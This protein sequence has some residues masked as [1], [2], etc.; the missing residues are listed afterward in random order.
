LSLLLLGKDSNIIPGVEFSEN[1]A[2]TKD[3]ILYLVEVL[4]AWQKAGLYLLLIIHLATIVYFWQW[5][6][7]PAHIN[8]GWTYAVNTTLIGWIMFLPW[9]FFFFVLRMKKPNPRLP[10]PAYL[11]AAMVVTKAP[12]EPLDMV[13]K[14][15]N[16]MI[17]QTYPHDTWL[18]DED[19]TEEIKFWCK[20]HGVRI[21]TRKGVPEYNRDQWPRRKKSKEGNL[22]F[23]YDHYGYANYDVVCQLDADHIPGEKY[24]EEMIRPF[25]DPAV[26]YVSAPSICD[27]NA[28]KSWTARSRLYAEAFLHGAQQ[29]GH[30][31]NFAPLCFGSHY[32]VRTKALREIGGLGPELAED[33]STTL[34]LNAGG[35][36]GVH[37]LEAEAHG[38]GPANFMDAMTQEFQWSKSLFI[39]F[40]T[41]TPRVAGKLGWRLKGQF[42]F[43][44]LWYLL[45]GLFIIIGYF[46]PIL[47]IILATSWVNVSY[48]EFLIRFYPVIMSTLAVVF[49]LKTVGLMR[50]RTAKILSWEP[51]LFQ[52]ARWPWVLLGIVSATVTVIRKK[53]FEFKVTPKGEKNEAPLPIGALWPYALFII[54]SSVPALAVRDARTANGYFYF[55][56]CNIGLYLAVMMVIMVRHEY[57]KK[58]V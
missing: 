8:N 24:L 29:A 15:L 35:W 41:L 27:K 12:S 10:F 5:W 52:L 36:K 54:A 9:Y 51:I 2:V 40:L 33:H 55:I 49:Y 53:Q 50:P 6:L 4:S 21:S 7:D 43:S 39:L 11:K 23:F 19:P 37:A 31:N 17:W 14:T 56:I 3:K 42:L 45:F 34:L 32:A 28:G 44:Q 46:L 26:G 57:E 25:A 38:D 30:S 1:M 22:A 13:L 47:A 18:A 48:V 20:Q 16:G 58:Y